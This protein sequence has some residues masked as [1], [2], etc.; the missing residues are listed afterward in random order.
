MDIHDAWKIALKNTEIIRSRIQVLLTFA[1]THVPYVL[2]SE[3]SINLGDTVVRK[4]EILVEKPSLILPPNLPQFEGFDFDRN[5]GFDEKSV[6]NFF[7]VRG[8]S[9]PSLRYNNKTC[10]LNVHEGKL[11]KAVAH[12][13]NLLQQQENVHTGLIVGPEDYWQFSILI[14]I[15]AQIARNADTDVKRILEEYNKGNPKD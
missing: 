8:I 11:N 6:M 13:K 14:F 3:S 1:D 7:L 12:Y 15:C 10:S 2:L 5:E 4:G 9:L